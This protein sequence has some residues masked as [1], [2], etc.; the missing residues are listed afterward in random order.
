MSECKE[1][2]EKVHFFPMIYQPEDHWSCIA[3]LSAEDMLKSVV[4]EEKKF[5]TRICFLCVS[6]LIEFCTKTQVL[7]L[8]RGINSESK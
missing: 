1:V 6:P 5:K 8:R 4:I 7:E 2:K 3:H